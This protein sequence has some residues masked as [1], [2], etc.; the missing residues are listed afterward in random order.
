MLGSSLIFHNAFNTVIPPTIANLYMNVSLFS[1][2]QN[3]KAE[4][5][6]THFDDI[7]LVHPVHAT[8]WLKKKI[9]IL[10]RQKMSISIKLKSTKKQGNVSNLKTHH[11][12]L[13][14]SCPLLGFEDMPNFLYTKSDLKKKN[15][16]TNN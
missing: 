11:V 1:F 3:Y 6:I 5:I 9:S 14:Y 7:Y 13:L 16:T 8:R 4:S 2:A 15:T 10:I 12:T